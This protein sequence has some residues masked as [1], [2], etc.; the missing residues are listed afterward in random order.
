MASYS[1]LMNVCSRALG[2]VVSDIAAKRFGMRG[3][4]WTLWFLQTASGGVCIAFGFC[5]TSLSNSITTMIIFSFLT[6]MSCGATYGIV[7]FISKRALGVVSGFVGAGGNTIA[8]ILQ[9]VF[10]THTQVWTEKSVSNLGITIMCFTALVATVHFPQ[11]GGM[12]TSPSKGATE[13]SYYCK[14]WTAEE[15]EQGMDRAAKLFAKESI[16][17]RGS[18]HGSTAALAELVADAKAE[19]AEAALPPKA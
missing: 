3:R 13:E 1:G 15:R 6:Q 11:W 5:S 8:A 2:G 7:P 16:G 18:K 19:G 12:F 10:F 17:E 9:Y 14:D 4:L